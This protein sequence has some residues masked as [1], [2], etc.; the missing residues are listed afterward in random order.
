MAVSVMRLA[1]NLLCDGGSRISGSSGKTV[2]LS[3][4]HRSVSVMNTPKC[5][6]KHGTASIMRPERKRRGPRRR[7]DYSKGDAVPE[8]PQRQRPNEII[9][10]SCP[11]CGVEISVRATYCAAICP[12]CGWLLKIEPYWNNVSIDDVCQVAGPAIEGVGQTVN[13]KA[14]AEG[15]RKILENWRRR[16]L[17]VLFE[18][19]LPDGSKRYRFRLR[20]HGEVIVDELDEVD[21]GARELAEGEKDEHKP[22]E[23]K[24][25]PRRIG[26]E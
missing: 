14:Y 12:A 2:C 16:G 10:S 18:E 11:R 23:L 7:L 24:P 4:L 6:A 17:V 21:Y 13:K 5:G 3:S 1:A 15:W 26:G 22:E 8:R 20:S 9:D 25:P 19:E